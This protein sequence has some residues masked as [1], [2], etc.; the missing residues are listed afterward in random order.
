[1]RGKV[2]WLGLAALGVADWLVL[3][4]EVGPAYLASQS[5]EA[6]P[7]TASPVVPSAPPEA[8]A[9]ALPPSKP[10]PPAPAPFEE[11]P[12]PEPAEPA[13]P[14]EPTVEAPAAPSPPLTVTPPAEQPLA[15]AAPI[16]PLLFGRQS[17]EL[18][19]KDRK[20]LHRLAKQLSKDPSASVLIE[21]H[22]DARGAEQF[23]EWLSLQRARAVRGYLKGLGVKPDQMQV[24]SHG[25]NRPADGTGTDTAHAKNRRV[26]LTVRSAQ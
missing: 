2:L 7:A 5:E 20:T 11:S 13:T 4:L 8:V 16:E 18:S 26:E 9:M 22:A 1:M 24:A 12:G 19:E 25:S 15:N 17:A 21:G 10:Q 3:N 14:P 6:P 23:N